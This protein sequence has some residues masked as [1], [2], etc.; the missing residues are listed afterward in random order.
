M[1]LT[2]LGSKNVVL[3]G[4]C[5]MLCFLAFQILHKFLVFWF[6]TNIFVYLGEFLFTRTNEMGIFSLL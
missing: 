5:A 2:F 3:G 1:K 4:N 6:Y